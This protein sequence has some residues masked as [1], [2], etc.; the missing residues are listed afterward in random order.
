[1][2]ELVVFNGNARVELSRIEKYDLKDKLLS[3][4]PVCSQN[5]GYSMT[6]YDLMYCCEKLSETIKE[7]YGKYE[8]QEIKNI[9]EN[10]F[11]NYGTE[12]KTVNVATC[13]EILKRFESDPIN[14]QNLQKA[15]EQSSRADYEADMKK[16]NE[17]E[18]KKKRYLSFKEAENDYFLKQRTKH[19]I[20]F[21]SN[22]CYEYVKEVLQ[23]NSI[24]VSE[25][26]GRKI[27]ERLKF[28]YESL[29]NNDEEEFIENK[30]M[31][32]SLLQLVPEKVMLKTMFRGVLFNI[33]ALKNFEVVKE[34]QGN[35]E[36]C[37]C[38]SGKKYKYCCKP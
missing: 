9:L 32:I 23:D 19:K 31:G 20:Y 5:M 13:S 30:K 22:R 17:N 28:I 7:K 1:M 33:W 21:N 11:I 10:G 38:G 25:E 15:R 3:I 4:I 24:M 12:L 36:P 37:A 27:Y 18:E 2:S 34:K 8:F 14:R 29:K 6:D 16:Y 26:K 35:N